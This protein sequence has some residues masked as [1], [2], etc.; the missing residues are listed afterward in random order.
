MNIEYINQVERALFGRFNDGQV[1]EIPKVR[2][3]RSKWLEWICFKPEL[4]LEQQQLAAFFSSDRNPLDECACNMLEVLNVNDLQNTNLTLESLSQIHYEKIKHGQIKSEFLNFDL[5][6]TQSYFSEDQVQ[7]FQSF[8]QA[9]KTKS[10]LG[11]KKEEFDSEKITKNSLFDTT[12]HLLFSHY[13]LV[14]TQARDS[15][16]KLL[17]TLNCFRSI[18]KRI[19]LDLREFGTRDRVM[20]DINHQRPIEK[21]Y[22]T[23]IEDGD[24]EDLSSSR[25]GGLGQDLDTKKSQASS[26]KVSAATNDGSFFN[27]PPDPENIITDEMV[28]INRFRL[29]N[30]M[31]NLTYSTC[32][33]VPKFHTTFGEPIDR[34]E[35]S[36]EFESTKDSDPKKGPANKQMG[37]ID[38]IWKDEPGDCYIVTDDYG[39]NIMYDCTFIDMRAVEQ[40]ILKIV[41]FYISKVEPMQ[42]RDM[43]N[44]LPSIDRLGILKEVLHWE[45]QY[46][47]SK[48]R[49]CLHYMECY[50]HTCDTLE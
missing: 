29:D 23:K 26:M 9:L 20:G 35:V 13:L 40:E 5:G 39:F 43:R 30:R 11:I 8:S 28:D 3:A 1:E 31:N 42:E 6:E 19:T 33:I 16:T 7:F 2:L 45:E 4:S 10:E 24:N 46:Q 41:S 17:Y 27:N 12:Q 18:Q 47:R 32:P 25:G 50:D 14:A 36:A 38:K 48:L 37:R 21:Q 49:L 34:Q 22:I 15:K 44:I